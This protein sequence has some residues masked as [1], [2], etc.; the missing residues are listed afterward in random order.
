MG[1]GVSIFLIA[2]GAVLTFAV[3]VTTNGLDL[4]AVGVILM[5]VGGLGILAD[6]FVFGDRGRLGVG[7]TTIVETRPDVVIDRSPI[8]DRGTVVEEE[9]AYVGGRAPLVVDPLAPDVAHRRVVRRRQ[10]S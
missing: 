6:L 3:N 5:L 8:V 10:V 4:S 7:R 1:I 2:V 9:E